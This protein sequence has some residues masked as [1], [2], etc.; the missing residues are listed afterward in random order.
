MMNRD[1]LPQFRTMGTIK[2]NAAG[3]EIIHFRIPMGPL[4]S[5]ICIVNIPGDGEKQAPVYVKIKAGQDFNAAGIH[6]DKNGGGGLPKY[7]IRDRGYGDGDGGK[8]DNG[9]VDNGEPLT[10]EDLRVE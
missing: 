8:R 3:G 2:D 7:D 10:D 4:G 9:F 1:Y 5:L 6:S